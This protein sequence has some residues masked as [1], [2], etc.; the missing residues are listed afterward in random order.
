MKESF[1]KFLRSRCVQW[2]IYLGALV[3]I[4]NILFSINKRNETISDSCSSSLPISTIIAEG[5]TDRAFSC[6]LLNANDLNDG[7]LYLIQSLAY[8][9]YLEIDAKKFDESGEIRPASDEQR[10][11]ALDAKLEILEWSISTLQTEIAKENAESGQKKY[12]AS[13]LEVI[14]EFLPLM[15]DRVK[16]FISMRGLEYDANYKKAYID[17]ENSE[18]GKRFLAILN[19]NTELAE[20]RRL[21]QKFISIFEK[22]PGFF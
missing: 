21:Y 10:I 7:G 9:T 16:I 13:R 12:N 11:E 15:L 6:V 4:L 1:K 2:C 22:E 5:E 19:Q 3:I 18:K 8:R 17:W 14:N 20:Q